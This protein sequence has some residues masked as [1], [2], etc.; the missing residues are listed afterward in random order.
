MNNADLQYE[1][2]FPPEQYQQVIPL[3]SISDAKDVEESQ[4]ITVMGIFFMINKQPKQVYASTLWEKCVLIDSTGW[5]KITIWQNDRERLTSET[6]YT[7]SPLL[8]KE[9]GTKYLMTTR[10]TTITPRQSFVDDEILTDLKHAPTC[11]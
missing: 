2:S 7:F 10:S 3:H 11:D 1:Y 8:L 5:M 9:C 6:P 4:L